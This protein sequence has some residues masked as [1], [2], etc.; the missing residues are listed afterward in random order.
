MK[1]V[2]MLRAFSSG[3]GM[4]GSEADVSWVGEVG[5]WVRL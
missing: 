4:G 3:V 2:W 5:W 1:R